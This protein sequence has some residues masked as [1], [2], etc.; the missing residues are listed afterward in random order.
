MPTGAGTSDEDGTQGGRELSIASIQ[1]LFVHGLLAGRGQPGRRR[2][3]KPPDGHVCQSGHSSRSPQRSDETAH[4]HRH[5]VPPHELPPGWAHLRL[6]GEPPWLTSDGT[7]PAERP[8]VPRAWSGHAHVPMH[9][10]APEGVLSHARRLHSWPCLLVGD[11]A[12]G[13]QQHL[14]CYPKFQIDHPRRSMTPGALGRRCFQPAPGER[15]FRVTA[16]RRRTASRC[17][18]AVQVRVPVAGTL[19]PVAPL[20]ATG[21]RRRRR[22]SAHP[23]STKMA[24]AI[25]PR[26]PSSARSH[27]SP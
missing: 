3:G 15:T 6:D 16:T 24:A 8:V 22:Y 26:K 19:S 25:L 17:L 2:D 12:Q 7:V 1:G 18:N 11:R 10:P 13:H 27:A 14:V 9:S 20:P 21:L 23:L 4:H 5:R